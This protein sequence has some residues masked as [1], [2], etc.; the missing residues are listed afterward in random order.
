MVAAV[1]AGTYYIRVRGYLDSQTGPYTLHV[2]VREPDDHGNS[3]SAATPVTL[4]STTPGVLTPGDVDYFRVVVTQ[5]RTLVAYTT[6]NLDTVG[7]LTDGAGSV[8]A[9][10][11]D[12]GQGANF[13]ISRSV[14]PGTYYIEVQGFSSST[15]GDYTLHVR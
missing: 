2:E 10:N 1:D 15:A 9:Y 6:G 12:G 7:S 14:R 3:P 8:F 5:R 13:R 11:D 4:P